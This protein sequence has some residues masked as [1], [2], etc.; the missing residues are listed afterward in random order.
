MDWELRGMQDEREKVTFVIQVEC[1]DN[2]TWQGTVNWSEEDRAVPFR[3]AMELLEIMNTAFDNGDV[4]QW[5]VSQESS[6]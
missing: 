5:E 3:S 1:Q 4:T 2:A 6:R